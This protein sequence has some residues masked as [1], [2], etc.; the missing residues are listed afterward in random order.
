[1]LEEELTEYS[2]ARDDSDEA[3]MVDALADSI[4]LA[5]NELA[6]MG[7]DVDLVMKQCVKH[8]S[9]RVQDPD[10]YLDWTVNGPSGKWQKWKDQPSDSIYEPDYTVC[11]LKRT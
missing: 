6:L 10:Q 1:M 2:D 11:R 5:S 3:G 9:A 8:I 4:V 7:Y